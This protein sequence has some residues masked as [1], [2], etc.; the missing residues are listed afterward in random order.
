[1]VLLLFLLIL[2]TVRAPYFNRKNI[3][4]FFDNWENLCADY[5]VNKNI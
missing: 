1:M 5:S 4:D 3:I 2:G